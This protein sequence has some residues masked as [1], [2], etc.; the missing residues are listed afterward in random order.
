M[1]ISIKCAKGKKGSYAGLSLLLLDV[2]RS[3]IKSSRP[4]PLKYLFESV[5]PGIAYSKRSA[6]II[7]H[8]AKDMAGIKKM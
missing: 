7:F 2:L 1:Q 5:T 3:Y 6:Q 8:K 4:K